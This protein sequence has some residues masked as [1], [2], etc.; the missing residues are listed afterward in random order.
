MGSGLLCGVE[1]SACASGHVSRPT[2]CGQVWVLSVMGITLP[3]ALRVFAP[4]MT[5]GALVVAHP[6]LSDTS[7]SG[8][9]KGIIYPHNLA[10]QAPVCPPKAPT[11]GWLTLNARWSPTSTDDL[12]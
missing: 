8:I 10:S 9:S 4:V 2:V 11:F 5:A 6:F 7:P 1:R 12:T 3:D